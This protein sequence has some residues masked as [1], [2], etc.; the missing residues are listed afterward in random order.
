[1]QRLE[2]T[3]LKAVLCAVA[4]HMGEY[5]VPVGISG[6]HIHVSE[7]ALNQLF[8]HGYQLTPLKYLSQPGQY[9]CKETISISGEKGLIENVRILGPLR[10]DTQIELSMTDCF[11]IGVSPIIRQ[12]GDTGGSDGV[13]L[14]GPNGSMIVDEGVIVAARHLH[15]SKVQ[16]DAYKLKDGDIV[17]LEKLGERPTYFGGF[18]VRVSDEFDLEAHLDSDEANAAAIKNG[19]LLR[20]SREYRQ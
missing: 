1:M 12:S 20:M 8:G 13:E 17:N 5:Y 11:K 18:L 19:D 7:E 16:A 3:V 15:L 4:A 2:D 9:A 14:I 10:G 6:R